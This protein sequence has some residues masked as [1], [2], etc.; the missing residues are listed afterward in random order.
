M[1]RPRRGPSTGP[2]RALETARRTKRPKYEARALTLLGQALV[3]L[4]KRDEA[5]EALRSAVAMADD[6]VGPP[7]RWS[8]RAALGGAAYAVGDD[9]TAAT[10]YGEAAA[11]VES[12][13]A[14]LAPER[15]QRLLAAP[16]IEEI[17]SA[18]GRKPVA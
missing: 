1:Q 8:A 12:F 15:A 11:L 2:D 3:Q 18:A 5:L 9:D 16:P 13:A 17:L 10:A 4:R 14:T 7:A 6:L